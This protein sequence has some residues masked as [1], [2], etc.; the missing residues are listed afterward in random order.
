MR[1]GAVVAVANST[2]EVL[3]YVG[4]ARRGADQ[5]AGQMD[6]IG[7]VRQ[8][9]STLKPFV[10]ELLFEDGETAATLLDDLALP[11]TG[12]GE[13]LFEAEDYDGQERGPVRARVALASSLNLAALDAARRVG[14][15]RIVARLRALGVSRLEGADHYGA[16]IVLGGA[17]ITAEELVMAYAALARGG[18][19]IPLSYGPGGQ[20]VRPRR[21]MD[22][23]AAAIV[24]DILSD[25]RARA[26][27]FGD[28]LS[29]LIEESDGE[30]GL[31]TGTSSGWHDAWAAVF[32]D[33]VTVV[34]WLGD[35]DGHPL[36]AVS[37]FEGAAEPAVRVLA[38]AHHRAT[39]LGLDSAAEMA[40]SMVSDEDSVELTSAEI[41]AHSG[42]LAGDRCPRVI[43]EHF[44]RGTIPAR[45][46]RDH[47]ADGSWI[48]PHRYAEWVAR[49]HP[50]GV[51]LAESVE[52]HPEAVL[53]VIHPSP[54]ARWLLDPTRGET[55][56]PLRAE[57]QGDPPIDVSWEV[58]GQP[59]DGQ[60]WTASP[61]RHTFVAIAHDHRSAP[62]ELEV[63]AAGDG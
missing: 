60:H 62:V 25:N 6:L 22:P 20:N 43:E 53:R 8:P 42:L 51:I 3:A 15:H 1:Q 13:I 44:I 11:M 19:R 21:V 57:L 32:T 37:G 58:N 27:A 7:A 9:G 29:H 54:G 2:G 61:G 24:V 31:K 14:P 38:A 26:D 63:V 48:V 18:T 46:C 40:M 49:A 4:A 55:Q 41:C 45:R 34:L 23:Q 47:R 12:A 56:V 30:L 36:G 39:E 52:V 17:D 50:A 28:D 35:P 16:A 5:P 59:I 33:L 10:Y